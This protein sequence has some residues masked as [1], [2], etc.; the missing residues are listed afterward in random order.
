MVLPHTITMMNQSLSPLGRIVYSAAE[1]QNTN[2]TQLV[3]ENHSTYGMVLYLFGVLVVGALARHLMKGLPVP[4]TVI[5]FIIGVGFGALAS[6]DELDAYSTMADMDGHMILT[7]FLPALIFESSFD[8]DL[9][10]FK[11]SMSQCI[12][13]ATAGVMIATVLTAFAAKMIFPYGWEWP[14]ALLYGCIASATDPVAVVA[15]LGEVGASKKLATVIEGESL[16]NDG[17]AIVF[18][19][20]LLKAV[21]VGSV[22]FETV[23]LSVFRMGLCGPLIGALAGVVTVMWLE[24]VHNDA[25][26]EITITLVAAYAV[27]YIAEELQLSGVLAVVSLG[28]YLNGSEMSISK[29]VLPNLHKFWHMVGYLANTVIFHS[30][31][32]IVSQSAIES[33]VGWKDISL[34]FLMYI[35]LTA[36][37]GATLA[38]LSPFLNR[39]G[40]YP[41]T[42]RTSLVITWGGLRGAVGLALA[43]VVNQ[44]SRIDRAMVGSKIL[45]HIGG[46]VMLTLIINAPTV[47]LL[48]SLLKLDEVS[49]LGKV[50]MKKAVAKLAD[51]QQKTIRSLKA[52]RFLS[53]SNWSMVEEATTILNPLSKVTKKRNK[54]VPDGWDGS[55]LPEDIQSPSMMVRSEGGFLGDTIE[56]DLKE[57]ARERFLNRQKIVF[58]RLYEEGV[59]EQQSVRILEGLVDRA[60]DSDVGALIEIEDLVTTWKIPPIFG[61]LKRKA[62][63]KHFIKWRINSQLSSAFDIGMAFIIASEEAISMLSTTMTEQARQDVVYRAN[64]TMRYVHRRLDE[65]QMNYLDITLRI[66]TKHAIGH[67]LQGLHRTLNL[68]KENGIVD[69][70]DIRM[71]RDIIES[72]ELKAEQIGAVPPQAVESIMNAIDWVKSIRDEEW[73]EFESRSC[74]RQAILYDTGDEPCVMI[75]TRGLGKLTV[76]GDLAQNDDFGMIPLSAGSVVGITECMFN[77]TPSFIITTDTEMEVQSIPF[78]TLMD[79][80]KREMKLNMLLWQTAGKDVANAIL[81]EIVPYKHMANKRL[82]ALLAKGNTLYAVQDQLLNMETME[83]AVLLRGT[84]ACRGHSVLEGPCFVPD[85][86]TQAKVTTECYIFNIIS[87]SDMTGTSQQSY[88]KH[89]RESG[90]TRKKAN[91]RRESNRNLMQAVEQQNAIENKKHSRSKLADATSPL[92]PPAQLNNDDGTRSGNATPTQSYTPRM[93]CNRFSP[94]STPGNSPKSLAKHTHHQPT[95]HSNHSNAPVKTMYTGGM[96]PGAPST[97]DDTTTLETMETMRIDS[98]LQDTS[99]LNK[100]PLSEDHTNTPASTT[101]TTTLPPRPVQLSDDAIE[102]AHSDVDV[103]HPSAPPATGSTE[104]VATED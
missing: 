91:S 94:H 59:L 22:T 17:T 66:K 73:Y 62:G 55:G 46:F 75:V 31:G 61:Y 1:G 85:T 100:S 48:I 103:V 56:Q 30:A 29:E 102:I 60:M 42:W 4:Y 51:E 25:L 8:L 81:Q 13:M 15:L 41:I 39:T 9:H 12:T 36:I 69:T 92:R 50:V 72:K 99:M 67:I 52:N 58:Y 65:L 77:V 2:S 74:P 104:E 64:Q 19:A 86:C 83:L 43:L 63:I 3:H 26:V 35:I 93:G 21:A 68:I 45:F 87:N 49:P 34:L 70:T 33:S 7:I 84:L 57:A 53:D 24:R 47:K 96:M 18:F 40:G 23:I 32:L 98:A 88:S 5:M 90:M 14:E 89:R 6:F 79:L 20:V 54:I 44:E 101:T 37:R 28:V 78:V 71:L 82:K 76:S 16:L 38:L 27:Y 95:D 80:A 11:K 97:T 10:I